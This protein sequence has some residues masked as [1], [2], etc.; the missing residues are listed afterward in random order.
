MTGIVIRETPST[1]W[2]ETTGREI[3]EWFEKHPRRRVCHVDLGRFGVS[4]IKRGKV[5]QGLSAAVGSQ[6]NE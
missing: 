2:L 5:V 1:E 4:M 6:A 3:K